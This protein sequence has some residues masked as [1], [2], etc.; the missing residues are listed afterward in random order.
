[1][2]REERSDHSRAGQAGAGQGRGGEEWMRR[3]RGEGKGE[4]GRDQGR[5]REGR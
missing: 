1:M 5:G 2:L 4:Q 3:G